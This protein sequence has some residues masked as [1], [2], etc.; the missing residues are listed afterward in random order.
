MNR[1]TATLTI[2]IITLFSSGAVNAVQRIAVLNF[3]LNDI[4][5]LPNTP[6]EQLRTAS[7]GPLLEQALSQ[8]GNCEIIQINAADQMV[9]NSSFGYLF[10]F[11]D[12]A[13]KLGAQVGADWIV[14]GQHSK[15]SFLFSYLMA[16]LINV[17]T[18]TLAANFAIEL[19]GNHE[20]VT[21]RGVRVLATKIDASINR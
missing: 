20:K 14:V 6:Q 19:K 12:L 11:N 5:S 3:E 7:I 1:L 2:I 16:H 9:A 18:Q 17:K 10:R 21:K 15:P 4:T 8:D 13:A